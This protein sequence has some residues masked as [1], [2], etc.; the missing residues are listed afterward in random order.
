MAAYRRQTCIACPCLITGKAR[1]YSCTVVRARFSF[2]LC[3]SE[4]ARDGGTQWRWRMAGVRLLLPQAYSPG[5]YL[6]PT[7]RPWPCAALVLP[8]LT[9][10]LQ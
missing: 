7:P 2:F 10:E 1:S 8:A 9:E 3:G 4:P 5:R 6:P